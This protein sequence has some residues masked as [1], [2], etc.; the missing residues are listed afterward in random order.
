M[1][2]EGTDLTLLSE[3]YE[4]GLGSIFIRSAGADDE[5]RYSV[6]ICALSSNELGQSEEELAQIKFD[7]EKNVNEA[8]GNEAVCSV[9]NVSVAGEEH[10]AY[11][12][13]TDEDGSSTEN[14]TVYIVK[15]DFECIISISSDPGEFDDILKL[16]EKI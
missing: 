2:D 12:E 9:E 16:F 7:F 13:V 1:V 10:P 15:N 8:L 4:K 14:A 6:M 11:T 3:T 5:K